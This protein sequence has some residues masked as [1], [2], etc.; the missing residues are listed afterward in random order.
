MNSS[1]SS[2]ERL[3]RIKEALAQSAVRVPEGRRQEPLPESVL[4]ELEEAGA[5]EPIPKQSEAS[6]LDWLLGHLRKPWLAGAGALAALV[7]VAV[8]LTGPGTGTDPGPTPSGGTGT[9]TG[10]ITI[11]K[12]PLLILYQVSAE[13]AATLRSEG[14]FRPEQVVDVAAGEDLDAVLAK[15]EQANLVLVDGAKGVVSAPFGE[16]LVPDVISYSGEI[17]LSDAVGSVL[18]AFPEP[19]ETEE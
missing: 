14:L 13:E 15:R 4:R 11:G 3:K 6:F 9:R 1:D 2:P 19:E 10:P 7:I 5:A 16:E 8:V 12:P 17:E 18:A